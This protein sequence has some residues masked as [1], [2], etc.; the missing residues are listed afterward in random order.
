MI[1]DLYT[2]LISRTNHTYVE[3]LFTCVVYTIQELVD[4]VK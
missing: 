3:S 1:N 4:A 2:F